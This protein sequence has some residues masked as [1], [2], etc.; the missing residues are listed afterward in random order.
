MHHCGLLCSVVSDCPSINLFLPFVYCTVLSG[1]H[2]ILVFPHQTVWQQC[3][4]IPL[5]GVLNAVGMN[6]ITIFDQYQYFGND[7]R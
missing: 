4:G 2:T 3:D 5:T 7:T 1:S 6:K